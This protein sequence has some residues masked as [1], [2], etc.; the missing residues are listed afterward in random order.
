MQQIG[1][2]LLVSSQ[3][4]EDFLVQL[5]NK[6]CQNAVIYQQEICSE[7][8]KVEANV[9]AAMKKYNARVESIWGSTLYHIDDLDYN[10]KE[11]LPN[12]GT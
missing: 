9:K 5:L 4:P 2:N 6:D 12:T 11:Y 10:P 8:L 1:S 7:E 3:K